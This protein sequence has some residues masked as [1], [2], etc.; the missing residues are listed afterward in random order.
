MV[1]NGLRVQEGF[2]TRQTEL[3]VLPVNKPPYKRNTLK[4]LTCVYNNDG[5]SF[6]IF[7]FVVQ[8]NK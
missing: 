5:L 1:R 8:I 6:H 4:N 3:S 7:I 2:T